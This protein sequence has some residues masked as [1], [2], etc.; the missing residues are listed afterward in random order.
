MATVHQLIVTFPEDHGTY[1]VKFSQLNNQ[2]RISIPD[3]GESIEP[4]ASISENFRYILLEHDWTD[5]AIKSME[6]HISKTYNGK[7]FHINSI[8]RTT[9]EITRLH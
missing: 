5:D 2:I 1:S 8:N 4:K 6:T 3:Y 7:Y 9:G